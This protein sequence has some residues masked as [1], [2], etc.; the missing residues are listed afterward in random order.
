MEA[1]KRYLFTTRFNY[2]DALRNGSVMIVPVF[3]M[4]KGCP[5]RCIFCNTRQIAGKTEEPLTKD[6]LRRRVARCISPGRH[7]GGPVELAFYG[8]NFTGMPKREQARLLEIT[9]TLM[10]EDLIHRVRIATRPDDLPPDTL[11][12]LSQHRVGTIEI[13]VQSMIDDVLERSRRGHTAEDV[14]RSV[15]LAKERGFAVSVHLMAGLPGDT[16]EYFAETIRKIIALKPDMARLHPTLVFP[17]TTLAAMYTAGEYLPLTMANAISLCKRA[18]TQFDKAGIPL[19][20]LGLQE[21]ELMKMPGGILAGPFHPAF[22]S[23][24]EASIFLDMAVQL[25][26]KYN[27]MEKRVCFSVCPRDISSFR[28]E[29][30]G[31]IHALMTRFKLNDITIQPDPALERG[32]LVLA[33]AHH[34]SQQLRRMDQN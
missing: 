29:R 6:H 14:V 27:A 28:G 18:L 21:T 32:T 16:E 2:E 10:E 12:F 5:H 24:V 9:N 13:G 15:R 3:L 34:G 7:A 20:R 11:A 26:L 23:L 19:I 8:G 31:N 33:L 17:E 22:R 1:R 30:N 4:N 25:L